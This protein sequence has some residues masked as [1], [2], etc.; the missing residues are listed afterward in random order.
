MSYSIEILEWFS[1]RSKRNLRIFEATLL[2]ADEIQGEQQSPEYQAAIQK[3]QSIKGRL[4]GIDD[5]YEAKNGNKIPIYTTQK[6]L[7]AFELGKIT[8]NSKNPDFSS[9][10]N[11]LLS[12][13]EETG[14]QQPKPEGEEIPLDPAIQLA[15]SLFEQAVGKQVDGLQ[16]AHDSD[17]KMLLRLA[18][19]IN[20]FIEERKGKILISTDE[21]YASILLGGPQKFIDR[22][23]GTGQYS[24]K[25]KILE[26]AVQRTRLADGTT[27]E[28]SDEERARMVNE[29]FG[30]LLKLLS[31]DNMTA[32]DRQK[33]RDSVKIVKNPSTN[34]RYRILIYSEDKSLAL[35]LPYAGI[36]RAVFE[37]LSLEKLRDSGQPLEAL[38]VETYSNAYSGVFGNILENLTV[39]RVQLNNAREDL[40]NCKDENYR[41][42]LEQRC[43]N[44]EQKLK[45]LDNEF[46]EKV[47]TLVVNVRELAN[48]AVDQQ[49]ALGS[50][51]Y[52]EGISQAI[53][54]L[55]PILGDQYADQLKEL[56]KLSPEERNK[57]TKE[58]FI[59]LCNKVAGVVMFYSS[60][61]NEALT[62]ADHAVGVGGKVKGGGRRQDVRYFYA[63]ESKAKRASDFLGM[64]LR[65]F[66]IN[67]VE[68]LKQLIP[69]D[70]GGFNLDYLISKAKAKGQTK[71]YMLEDSVK[72]SL[73]SDGSTKLATIKSQHHEIETNFMIAALEKGFDSPEALQAMEAYNKFVTEKLNATPLTPQE[74]KNRM[75]SMKSRLGKV[76]TPEGTTPNQQELDQRMA[77]ALKESNRRSA[78][79]VRIGNDTARKLTQTIG[80]TETTAQKLTMVAGMLKQACK[81][82]GIPSDEETLKRISTDS[83]EEFNRFITPQKGDSE[84]VMER[85][86]EYGRLRDI[87]KDIDNPKKYEDNPDFATQ[88]VQKALS[89]LMNE[90]SARRI[91]NGNIEEAEVLAAT[92]F[93]K[94]GVS[95]DDLPISHTNYGSRTVGIAS[96]NGILEHFAQ[97]IIG[98]ARTRGAN[99][100][101]GI[102]VTADGIRIFT[103]KE[104]SRSNPNAPLQDA[105]LTITTK[106]TGNSRSGGETVG[107]INKSGMSVLSHR[108]KVYVTKGSET[109]ENAPRQPKRRK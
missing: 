52:I 48:I 30:H 57:Q 92:M 68:E 46:S 66:D 96:H 65:E 49:A 100:N 73:D 101:H 12:Q 13:K 37:G 1:K 107:A 33:Y 77:R 40:Q 80:G 93:S 58:L 56:E 27:I 18:R 70:P 99:K 36:S 14:E 79:L 108:R 102:S 22:F 87:L 10:L 53:S 78:T 7:I 85:K 9:K 109:K 8:I 19:L 23:I 44:L 26:A 94:L 20:K 55:T 54:E 45:Q 61:F 3:G 16:A 41:K 91:E 11:A 89:F 76:F 90:S 75:D 35:S 51:E 59:K 15:V 97:A 69:D 74:F 21:S 31:K 4:A 88:C 2:E 63:D 83:D 71:I 106:F 34:G 86:R 60:D 24:L 38:D 47:K 84:E 28:A 95:I 6:G 39:T 103:N 50:S 67:N 105:S 82:L 32:S 64:Q 81:E 62:N 25:R 98:M 72:N 104:F 29:V 5:P 43:S 42:A 17:G